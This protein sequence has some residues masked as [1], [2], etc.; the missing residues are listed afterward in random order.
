MTH[1][2]LLKGKYSVT[3]ANRTSLGAGK[4]SHSSEVA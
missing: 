1:D 3:G 2:I 4:M